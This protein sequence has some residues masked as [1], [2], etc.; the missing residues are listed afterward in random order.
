MSIREPPY[1]EIL[2][3]ETTEMKITAL[4]MWAMAG[5]PAFLNAITNGEAL[6]PEPPKRFGSLGSTVRV[7]IKLPR[8]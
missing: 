6:L 8:T 4:G 1:P 5:T 7:I 2:P 3:V